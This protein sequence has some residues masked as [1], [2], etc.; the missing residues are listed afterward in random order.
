M[1]IFQTGKLA[2]GFLRHHF[3]HSV[4]INVKLIIFKTNKRGFRN[5]GRVRDFLCSNG[6]FYIAVCNYASHFAHEYCTLNIFILRYCFWNGWIERTSSPWPQ[7]ASFH[8]FSLCFS[9]LFLW[10][11]RLSELKFKHVFKYDCHHGLSDSREFSGAKSD[12]IDYLSFSPWHK[13]TLL[14]SY[15]LTKFECTSQSPSI[16]IEFFSPGPPKGHGI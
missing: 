14:R 8:F 6:N 1:Y 3:W 15:A 4:K 9:V 12:L 5:Q 11:P 7:L 13:H 16:L 10:S 2:L